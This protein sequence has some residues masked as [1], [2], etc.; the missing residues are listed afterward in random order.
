V[1]LGRNET[2]DEP[3][4]GIEVVHPLPPGKGK[5]GLGVRDTAEEGEDDQEEGVWKA[6]E[7]VS[8]WLALL[9]AERLTEIETDRREER[10]RSCEREQRRPDRG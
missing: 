1:G 5:V 7:R 8:R 6:S 4:E 3:R 2:G 10:P 9:L